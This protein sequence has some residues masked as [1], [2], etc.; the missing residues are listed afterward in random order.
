MFG[1]F[2]LWQFH[3]FSFFGFFFFLKEHFDSFLS[4]ECCFTAFKIC[5]FKYFWKQVNRFVML[6]QKKI[7]DDCG[8]L[9][10]ISSLETC[11]LM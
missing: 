1:L 6:L 11:A 5:V 10:A 7:K 3:A 9:L 2:I 8:N 4:W